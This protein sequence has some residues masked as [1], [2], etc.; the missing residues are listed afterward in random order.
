MTN[1]IRKQYRETSENLVAFKELEKKVRLHL[2]HS[3]VIEGSPNDFYIF[4]SDKPMEKSERKE[5]LFGHVNMS[6][7]SISVIDKKHVKMASELAYKLD[8]MVTWTL[9]ESYFI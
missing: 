6:N 4:Y 5:H 8:P 1:V 3:T 2:G 9:E 7:K